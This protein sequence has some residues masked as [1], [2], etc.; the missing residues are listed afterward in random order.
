MLSYQIGLKMPP[1]INTPWGKAELVMSENV[2]TGKVEV[3][4]SKKR[5]GELMSK[6]EQPKKSKRD[7]RSWMRKKKKR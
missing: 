6:N 7:W 4:M 5:Y 2:A 3:F 1:K